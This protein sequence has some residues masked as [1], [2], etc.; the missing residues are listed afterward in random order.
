MHFSSSRGEDGEYVALHPLRRHVVPGAI[1]NDGSSDS[2]SG[3]AEVAALGV[4]VGVVVVGVWDTGMFA[5]I[6]TG[7][8]AFCSVTTAAGCCDGCI[9]SLDGS[10]AG[11][12]STVECLPV[13]HG[14][15]LR[16]SSKLRTRGLQHFQPM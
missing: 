5:A 7:F 14:G 1:S 13:V 12:S 9:L 8:G 3:A 11:V 4:G 10:G 16:N 6:G 15:M 2:D